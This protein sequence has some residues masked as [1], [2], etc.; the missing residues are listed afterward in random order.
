MLAEFD[1]TLKSQREKFE[2]EMKKL[3]EQ[4]QTQIA[5]MVTKGKIRETGEMQVRSYHWPITRL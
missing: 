5:G 4:H 3:K 2:N 1:T